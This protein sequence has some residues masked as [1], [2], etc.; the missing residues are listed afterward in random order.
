MT[1]K[2]V[3]KLEQACN[4][5]ASMKNE[6][7]KAL[8]KQVPSDKFIRTTL[9]AV[10]NNPDIANKLK[11]GAISTK[12]LFTACMRAAQDGLILDNN[13]AALSTFG[14]EIVYMP[15]VNGILKKIRNSGEVS[16]ITAKVIYEKDLFEYWIDEKGEHFK[17]IPSEEDNVGQMKKVF[18]VAYF[19][20]GSS[21]LVVMKKA[22]VMKVKAIAKTKKIW[23]GPFEDQM[24]EKTALRR[25]AKRLP[26]SSD[27][28]RLFEHDNDNYEFEP[29]PSSPMDITPD[30]LIEPEKKETK[31]AA[32]VKAATKKPAEQVAEQMEDAEFTEVDSEP[33]HPAEEAEATSQD[34]DFI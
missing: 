25:L 18:A 17:Y 7:H 3:T 13:E 33:P 8:P 9:N 19:K 26:S 28:E 6:F 14:N 31:A 12:S 34:G 32:A 29:E 10:Q 24:W 23:E 16:T 27:L 5:I 15:M 4:T 21:Q 30:E 11:S 1:T 20:D 22:E 2:V